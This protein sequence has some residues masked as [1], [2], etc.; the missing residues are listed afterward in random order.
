ML[1]VAA[2]RRLTGRKSASGPDASADGVSGSVDVIGSSARERLRAARLRGGA[3]YNSRCCQAV[4]GARSQLIGSAR[5]GTPSMNRLVRDLGRAVRSVLEAV[6]P[7]RQM[8]QI[9]YFAAAPHHR[10]PYGGPLNGQAGRQRIV[11]EI[12]G[13]L[14]FDF[15]WET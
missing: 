12:F 10:E 11:N 13:C 5:V 6:I 15:V 1:Q 8:G 2:A 3:V 7:E 9:E 14:H 4:V